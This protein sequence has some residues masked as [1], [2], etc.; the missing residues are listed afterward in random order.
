[1]RVS[2]IAFTLLAGLAPTV[3]AGGQAVFPD[4][5]EAVRTAFWPGVYGNGGSTLYC[6]K[7]FSDNEGGAIGTAHIYNIK[8]IKSALRCLTDSQCALITPQ[9]IFMVSDLHNLYPTE[10]RIE[11][12]RRNAVF[13]DLKSQNRKPNDLGCGTQATFHVIEPRDEAKGNV[14]RAI[15]Y[16]HREYRLPIGEQLDVLKQWNRMDP[17][18]EE[19][20]LRNARIAQ[21]Q[22][23]RNVFIDNPQLA[24]ELTGD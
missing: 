20:K 19:E 16:M 4:L 24:D 15:F 11:T 7:T 2:A 6:G 3:H 18:D 23:V 12:G 10:A 13:G 14:A 22:G 9:Y 17:P 1:M 21:L 5:D 8:Q